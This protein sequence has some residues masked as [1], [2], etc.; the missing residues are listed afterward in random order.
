LGLSA[1]NG[2]VSVGPRDDEGS[3]LVRVEAMVE[4]VGEA[5]EL[6]DIRRTHRIDAVIGALIEE[7][8]LA[9]PSVSPLE[10]DLTFKSKPTRG[11]PDGSG[12]HPVMR[13][14]RHS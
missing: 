14:A 7:V 6:V 12:D 10:H 1:C 9:H 8:E 2:A 11:K 4:S 3:M 13:L 5:G